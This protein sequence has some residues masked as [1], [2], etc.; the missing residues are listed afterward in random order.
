M[1][2]V[3]GVARDKVAQAPLGEEAVG[4]VLLGRGAQVERHV[5]AVV[6]L[7]RALSLG[8]RFDGVAAAAVG[9]PGK[10]LVRTVGAAYHADLVGNH[11]GGVE[12]HAKLADDVHVLALVIGVCLLEGLRARVGDGAQVLV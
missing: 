1:A 10:C 8:G 3:V 4:V 7:A 11:E 6:V 2:H 9:L 5:G 12:A